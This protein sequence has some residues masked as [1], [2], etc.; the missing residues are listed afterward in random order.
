[1]GLQERNQLGLSVRGRAATVDPWG[2][3]MQGSVRFP[4][5][6]LNR[7]GVLEASKFLNSVFSVF[8]MCYLGEH[9]L[10]IQTSVADHHF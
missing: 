10:T 9:K 3:A 8:V 4:R 1:M 7:K 5:D 2:K 6:L